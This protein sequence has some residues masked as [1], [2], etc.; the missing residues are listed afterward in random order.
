MRKKTIV[1]TGGAGFIG[2]NLIKFL[3]K[4]TVLNIIS[5]DNYSSGSKL[6]HVLDK[7]V[8]YLNE[9]TL[10]IDKI[11]KNPK[12]I[13]SI[14]HF[15][16]FSRIFQS[17]L[18]IKECLNSN[19]NGTNSVINFCLKNKIHLIYSAT[20]ASLGNNG[21]DKNFHPMHLQKQKIWNY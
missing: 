15:G 4:N 8:K 21:S 18:N 2:S 3:L 1:V 5:I 20:S 10:N 17:F 16:E 19:C 14:F 12:K 13:D 9:D 11:I 6:N 7:R